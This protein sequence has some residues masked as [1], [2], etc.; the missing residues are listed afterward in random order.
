MILEGRRW[1]Y[2]QDITDNFILE[3]VINEQDSELSFTGVRM[4]GRVPV[5]RT[6]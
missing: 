5:S 4:G 2:R 6:L 1:N 3:E